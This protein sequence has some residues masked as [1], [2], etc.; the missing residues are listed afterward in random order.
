MG[1]LEIVNSGIGYTQ[2]GLEWIR[3]FLIKIAEYLPIDA[4]L[5]VMILFLAVSLFIGHFI[6]K[7]FVTRPWQLS[8]IIYTLIISI[9]L[10]FNL[11][12]L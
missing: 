1:I 10:F 12:Y 2:Q 5:S 6:A 8:Y 7:R 4:E 3:N 9:S 11:M